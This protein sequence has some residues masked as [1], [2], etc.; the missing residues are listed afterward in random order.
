MKSR[1]AMYRNSV[2]QPGVAGTKQGQNPKVGASMKVPPNT[3]EYCSRTNPQKI[4]CQ[5]DARLYDKGT[6]SFRNAWSRFSS[7]NTFTGWA[8]L[9]GRGQTRSGVVSGKRTGKETPRAVRR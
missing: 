6:K 7:S 1:L 2:S 8:A 4:S 9:A 3:H 5:N